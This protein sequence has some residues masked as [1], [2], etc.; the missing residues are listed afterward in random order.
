MSDPAIEIP[1]DRSI[2]R[3]ALAP[4]QKPDNRR[5]L[6]QLANTLVPYFLLWPVM[7][8]SLNVSYLLTLA[9]ALLTTGFVARI[10]II[11]HDCGHGSFFASRRGNDTVGIITG[12]ITWTP[13]YRWRRDHAIHHATSGDLDRRGTGDVMVMTVDEFQA[14]SPAKRWFYALWRHPLIMFTIGS[15][16]VFTVFHR[17]SSKGSGRRERLGVYYTNLLLAGLVCGM[18]W[19]IGWKAFLLIQVPI[20][21]FTASIGVWLF[22]V[23]HNFEGS[24]W[25]RH[26]NWDFFRA[27]LKGSSFYKLPAVFQWFSGNI[28]FHHIHHLDSKIPNYFLQKCHQ[29]NPIFQVKPLTF[30]QSLRCMRLRLWD[31]QNKR[32]VG[33]DILKQRKNQTTA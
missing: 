4:Y 1:Y 10:F 13:Y 32:M 31:E 27:S 22:Y 29:E 11:F 2:I 15:F 18:I 3:Q 19:L 17:F 33:F 21:F 16:L 7:V 26:P 20:L 24:Y 25:E 5:S 30:M 9:L 23:Q 8:W 28:G 12:L 14:L 6:W